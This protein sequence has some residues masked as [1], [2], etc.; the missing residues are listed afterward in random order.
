MQLLLDQSVEAAH[1]IEVVARLQQ[2]ADVPLWSA[3]ASNVTFQ[4]SPSQVS[5]STCACEQDSLGS[6]PM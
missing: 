2:P 6:L 4:P 3:D 1:I 5:G